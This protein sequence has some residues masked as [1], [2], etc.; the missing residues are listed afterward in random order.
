MTQ[1]S[2]QE[3]AVELTWELVCWES[4]TRI[5]DSALGLSEPSFTTSPGDALH[6]EGTGVGGEREGVSAGVE[7]PSI[8]RT[9][10][11]SMADEQEALDL[12]RDE[13]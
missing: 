7:G 12:Q 8:S 13:S 4:L 10:L 9:S 3:S 1:G 11:K 6:E 5:S 2:L